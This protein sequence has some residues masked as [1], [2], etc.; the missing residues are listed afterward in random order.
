MTAFLGTNASSFSFKMRQGNSEGKMACSV[1][2]CRS[3]GEAQWTSEAQ[4]CC[5]QLLG[6]SLLALTPPY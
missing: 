4:M 6:C 1:S 3:P 2:E 5:V